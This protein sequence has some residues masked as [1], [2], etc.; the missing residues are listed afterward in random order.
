MLQGVRVSES[1]R[2]IEVDQSKQGRLRRSQLVGVEENI[3][4]L[5]VQVNEPVAVQAL[6]ISYLKK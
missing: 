6:Q 5:Y 2:N 3:V 4:R 1:A